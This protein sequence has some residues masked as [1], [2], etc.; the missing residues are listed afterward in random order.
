[1]AE[2]KRMKENDVAE[3]VLKNFVNFFRIEKLRF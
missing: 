2:I 1:V 3:H